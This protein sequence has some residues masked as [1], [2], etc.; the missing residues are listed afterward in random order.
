MRAFSSHPLGRLI[1]VIKRRAR[2]AG[3][4]PNAATITRLIGVMLLQQND[5]WSL[6]RRCM[7]L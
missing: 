1:A 4:F 7:Q 3:M 5:K 6:N 2:V